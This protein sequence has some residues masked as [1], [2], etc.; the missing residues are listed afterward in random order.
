[1]WQ[2]MFY[3]HLYAVDVTDSRKEDFVIGETT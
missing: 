1:M 3:E 2:G